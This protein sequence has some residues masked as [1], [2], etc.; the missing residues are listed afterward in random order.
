MQNR[1]RRAAELRRNDGP[2][3]SFVL[4]SLNIRAVTADGTRISTLFSLSIK[5]SIIGIIYNDGI[6][7]ERKLKLS[8]GP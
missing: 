1:R 3:I 5:K 7:C 2:F 6:L 4:F 8:M